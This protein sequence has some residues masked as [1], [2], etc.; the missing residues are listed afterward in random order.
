MV[1]TKKTTAAVEK[2]AA[3]K[4]TVKAE[5]KATVKNV[6]EK[7][8]AAAKKVADKTAE[9]KEASEKKSAEKKATAK[10]LK[11]NVKI[12]IQIV[13]TLSHWI[14]IKY[15]FLMNLVVKSNN[16]AYFII[17]MKLRK[18]NLIVK[19]QKFI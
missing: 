10:K 5:A 17:N 16:L 18:I 7:V 19:I 8:K 3:T 2:A 1:E 14:K 15:V 9:A 13:K 12:I 11:K 6:E 4:E